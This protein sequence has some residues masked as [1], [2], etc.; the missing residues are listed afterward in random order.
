MG[1]KTVSAGPVTSSDFANNFYDIITS[2]KYAC[3]NSIG[4]YVL[5]ALDL[6]IPFFL[7]GDVP[8]AKVTATSLDYLE[9]GD[10]SFISVP[11]EEYVYSIFRTGPVKDIN[12]EQLSWFKDEAGVE[13]AMDLSELRSTMIN[14]SLK[15]LYIIRMIFKVTMGVIQRKIVKLLT[16]K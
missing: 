5:Y 12:E 11:R 4:T 13:V 1:F 9:M 14:L 15:H 8:Q 2:H 3:S 10:I 16:K 6:N 7:I